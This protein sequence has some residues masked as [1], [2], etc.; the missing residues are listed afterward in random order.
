MDTY[1]PRKLESSIIRNLD[2]F[3]SIAILGPRQC[4]KSTLIREYLK[5]QSH[6][7]YLDL[8]A[9]DDLNKLSEPTLFFEQHKDKLICLDEIQRKP[10]LFSILRSVIDRNN[11]NGQFLILGSASRDL[12]KQSSETLAGRIIYEHLTPFIFSEINGNMKLPD[13]WNRGGFPRSLLALD[14]ETSMLWRTNFVSTF[15]ERDIPQLGFSIA[16]QSLRRLWL[17]LAHSHGQL[18][19]FSKI[20]ESLGVSHTTVRSYVELLELTFMIRVLQPYNAN[21]KKRLVKTTKVYIRDTGIL[22]NLLQIRSYDDLLGH[23]M[24]GPSWEGLVIE[25]IIT[26]MNDWNAF[27]YRS[28]SGDEVDLILTR[29]M[30]MI[31]VECKASARPIPGK[32]F[33]TALTDLG[34]TRSFIIAPIDDEYQL[35]KDVWIMGIDQFFKRMSSL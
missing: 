24:F 13:Y 21:L 1:I 12:I 33:F 34:L 25:N 18:I 35:K 28:S 26:T 20:G 9:P 11:R 27:F 8:Q 17:M 29:G 4:G 23:P 15:L 22:H 2:N 6:V 10:E 30:E 3:P 32:R 14:S 31:G 5:Q 7:L 16:P 19:N